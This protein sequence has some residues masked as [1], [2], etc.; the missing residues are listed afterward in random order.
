MADYWGLAA[1]PPPAPW[2]QQ[3]R[4]RL[5][6]PL[7]VTTL[8]DLRT[9]RLPALVRRLRSVR[10]DVGLLLDDGGS[11]PLAPALLA[12]LALTRCRRL[13]AVGDGGSR[14]ILSRFSAVAAAIRMAAA[15]ATGL[16]SLLRCAAEL[17]ALERPA[18]SP[19]WPATLRRVVVLRTNLW[20]GIRA[21]GSVG[22]FAGVVNALSRGG[23]EVQVIAPELQPMLDSGVKTDCVA[24]P[25]D[26]AYPYELNYYTYQRRFV[27]AARKVVARA[28]PDAIYHRLSLGS[29]AGASLARAFKIPLIVEYNGSEVWV[30]RHWGRRLRFER[31]ATRAEA[32]G[33]RAADLI[34]VVSEPLST[35]LQ[36][37]G[38]PSERI[39]VHPNGV[40][41]ELF[42]PARFSAADLSRWRA[43]AGLPPEATVCTFVGTFGPWHGV[44]VL[45]AAIAI[46]AND[47]A[48][49]A[50]YRVH[51]LLIGDGA[52]MP[53]ARTRLAPVRVLRHSDR[54]EA[55]ARDA[56]LAGRLRRAAVAARP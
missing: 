8:A 21:G 1:Y 29:W 46:V 35:E 9:L 7:H 32:V 55:A 24:G 52:L 26:P 31:L 43:D 4:V 2:L 16:V 38:I 25:A 30:S 20:Y 48:W 14:R 36:S 11:G 17:R 51:F 18:I 50:R 49:L 53:Q 15:T 13:E 6:G 42:D 22:H 28:R 56:R 37:R 3:I 27:A 12:L 19:A 34:T 47:P 45:T 40:D 10:A 44:D 41:P 33:L 5:D 23:S 39:L 54:V